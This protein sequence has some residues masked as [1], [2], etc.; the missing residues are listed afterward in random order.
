MYWLFQ[1][2]VCL[3][4]RYVKNTM[5]AD[6]LAI[7]ITRSSAGMVVTL[8]LNNIAMVFLTKHQLK[9]CWNFYD[10]WIKI[11]GVMKTIQ[12]EMGYWVEVKIL[13]RIQMGLVVI[14]VFV[15]TECK[16][17]DVILVCKSMINMDISEYHNGIMIN[18]TRY[19]TQTLSNFRNSLHNIYISC[20]IKKSLH[21]K[22]L[23]SK[24][25]QNHIQL[26][27]QLPVSCNIYI[28][29]YIT[30]SISF[31]KIYLP[32]NDSK[33]VLSS[34]RLHDL[35]QLMGFH[36][37]MQ[38]FKTNIMAACILVMQRDRVLA[39]GHWIILHVIFQHKQWKVWMETISMA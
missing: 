23:W 17:M 4:L 1:Y 33:Y 36:Q 22:I 39:K 35:R 12:L 3:W 37:I 6:D 24:D 10:M 19:H 2:Q 38:H 28:Y 7:Y 30:H 32:I 11:F 34:I 14:I 21:I 26:T 5:S 8:A 25:C 20:Q 15:W 29:I 16:V 18:D 27:P 9:L 13:S 31:F